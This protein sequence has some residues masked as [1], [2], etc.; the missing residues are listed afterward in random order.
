MLVSWEWWGFR[1]FQK[2]KYLVALIPSKFCILN[3]LSFSTSSDFPSTDIW[4]LS[5]EGINLKV[6]YSYFHCIFWPIGK[7]VNMPSHKHY[8]LW[9]QHWELSEKVPLPW[10]TL[11]SW[12]WKMWFWTRWTG[13]LLQYLLTFSDLYFWDSVQE[14]L[15]CNI[16]VR[17]WPK[18]AT[19]SE[20]G[21][22]GWTDTYP[23]PQ[24]PPPH[25]E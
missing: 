7:L 17:P 8:L 20:D 18:W 15:K 11:V 5:T 22:L 13:L 23:I 19:S 16:N 12:D 9:K 21:S 1:S 6:D 14:G 3:S 2:N 4:W 24:Y 25:P 10:T